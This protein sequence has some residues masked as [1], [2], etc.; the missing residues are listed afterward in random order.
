MLN[1]RKTL[2]ASERRMTLS[3]KVFRLKA[4][5]S[6]PEWRRYGKMLLLGKVLGIA[7]VFAIMLGVPVMVAEAPKLIFGTAAQA[8]EAPTTA[9]TTPAAP[10][11]GTAATPAPAPDP[12]KLPIAKAEDVVNPINT[13]W[14]LLAA[15]L[16]FGIQVCFT[17]LES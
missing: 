3:E 10:A 11:E 8:Q 17:M 15:F 14:T 13:T 5:M 16:V 1:R 6:D 7:M 12:F 9:P 2:L 4:R